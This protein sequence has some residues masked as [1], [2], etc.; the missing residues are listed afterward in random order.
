MV[1]IF[2]AH[3]TA[4]AFPASCSFGATV[5]RTPNGVR[6]PRIVPIWATVP[7]TPNGVR[8]PASCTFALPSPADLTACRCRIRCKCENLLRFRTSL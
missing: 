6:I 3:L 4:C 5:P 8:T 1:D 2:P 7:R